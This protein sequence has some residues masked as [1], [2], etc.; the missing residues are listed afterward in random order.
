MYEHEDEQGWPC[1]GKLHTSGEARTLHNPKLT[2]DI[3]AYV[4]SCYLLEV[5]IDSSYKMHID[6]HVN[7]NPT[8]QDIDF[9]LSMKYIV[10]I[11]SCFMKGKY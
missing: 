4:E 3:V 5:S 11:Y 7:M 8:V 6:K 10:N 9:F 2:K 1:H